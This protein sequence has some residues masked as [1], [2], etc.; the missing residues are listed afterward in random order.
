MLPVPV[1]TLI[2]VIGIW[3][4]TTSLVE[5]T[6]VSDAVEHAESTVKEFK[7]IRAYY[8]QNVIKKVL[9]SGAL[10]PSIDHAGV[11]GKVPLPATMIHDLAKR[12]KKEGLYIN[13]YSK[14]PFPNRSSRQ[15]DA[16]QA[17][18]W[19]ELSKNPDQVMHQIKRVG[20][21]DFVQVAIADKMV[22]QAC[23]TCHNK[24]ADTPK[25]DWKLGDVRGIL[26]VDVDISNSLGRWSDF[27]VILTT[28]IILLGAVLS[29]IAF[30]M[31]NNVATPIRRLTRS[32]SSLAN[33]D[34]DVDVPAQDRQD[35]IGD[36]SRGVQY[37]KEAAT[38][39]RRLAQQEHAEVAKRQERQEK[40]AQ[41]TTSFDNQVSH[42]LGKVTNAVSTLN[43][44]STNLM[45]NAEQTKQQST[46]VASV[47]QQASSNV[48]TVSAA[49]EQ[50]SASIQ[51]IAHQVTQSST[52][53]TS[54]VEEVNE[55]NQKVVGLADSATKIGEVLKLINDIADQTNLLAL[56]ATIESARAGEAGKGFAVVA[57]EVKNLAGQ[58]GRATE[59]I[60]AQIQAIQNETSGAVH[61]I[62]GIAGTMERVN[63]LA[64][65]IA[66]AVE[67]QSAATGEIAQNIYQ[68]SEGASE[69]SGNITSV[70]TAAGH[71][72]QTAQELLDAAASL[73]EESDNL[74]NSVDTF[75]S[76]VRDA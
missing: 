41:L 48:E 43:G 54:A 21:K 24:R 75:L 15:L 45:A 53:L 4:Y 70:T 1:F 50:L 72:G 29:F 46:S 37:W 38:D 65:T 68:V 47:A 14:Y 12:L 62:Q 5:E 55:A 6:A 61:A 3:F 2:A 26:Q 63:E 11:E 18:A 32:M 52:L 66:S 64:T 76:S 56:N 23:V 42:V 9:G 73:T 74:K 13:L 60:A 59:E 31:G 35:E 39:R 8:T 25:N 69:I 19:D 22:A 28:L 40:I 16:F 17:R 36:L 71:T 67:E 58:T 57:S 30:Y 34:L 20:D 51:E 7:T 44:S 10:K 27:S 49:S 33:G